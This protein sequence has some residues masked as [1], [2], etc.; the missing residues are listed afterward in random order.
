MASECIPANADITGIGVRTATYAQN[1]LCFAPI[2]AHL[3][4]GKVSGDEIAGVK[5]QSIG[6]LAVA[7]AILVS[8]MVEAK[9]HGPGQSLTSFHAAIV[10]DLSWMNNTSTFI[11]FLLYAHQRS[12]NDTKG[13]VIPATWAG[14]YKH[15]SSPLR[16]LIWGDSGTSLEQ[17]STSNDHTDGDQGD[18]QSSDSK[19]NR[20]GDTKE[21]VTPQRVSKAY[22]PFIQ[23]LW[24]FV[25]GALVLTIGSIHLSMMSAIGIWLWRNPSRFGEHLDCDPSLTIVG[26][27]V[28][29][30]SRA[31]HKFSLVMYGILLVPGVNLL[32]GFVFFISLHILYNKFRKRLRRRQHVS[33]SD[34]EYQIGDNN[35]P[36]PSNPSPSHFPSRT[37][38]SPQPTNRH[39]GVQDGKDH[40]PIPSRSGSVHNSQNVSSPSQSPSQDD[41][42]V[43]FLVVGLVFLLIINAIFLADI[44]LTLSRNK[45]IRSSDDKQWGFGQVLALLLLIIPVR[46]FVKSIIDIRESIRERKEREAEV[47]RKT[48][49]QFEE[50]L[51]SA[52]ENDTLENYGFQDLIR[53]GAF[54]DTQ[55]NVDGQHSFT[56]KRNDACP[57]QLITGGDFVTLLQFAAYKGNKELVEYLLHEA[58]ADPNIRGECRCASEAWMRLTQGQEGRTKRRFKSLR[59]MGRSMWS[60]CFSKIRRRMLLLKVSSRL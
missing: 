34:E 26:S 17:A 3:W 18:K 1:V 32:P 29:F 22:M 48:Q 23:R 15:L 13:K 40:N 44:E 30:S 9:G 42:H 7:F 19:G 50:D 5:D 35:L 60:G 6:M 4:D 43:G 55:V 49:R 14:W 8:A 58:D 24:E 54:P 20:N 36:I 33:P 10:L 46:D 12:K 59:R 11:W 28:P 57:Y 38:S 25:S 56:Q 52:I 39:A 37:T 27:A 21:D 47:K 51:R 31:L 2:V 16:R 41:I 45:K 53:G